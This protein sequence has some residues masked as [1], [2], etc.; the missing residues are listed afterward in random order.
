LDIWKPSQEK[1]PT[2]ELPTVGILGIPNVDYQ[3]RPSLKVPVRNPYFLI[4]LKNAMNK[5]G[6]RL[7]RKGIRPE[8]VDKH[9]FGMR[10]IHYPSN[11][12]PAVSGF[13]F[14]T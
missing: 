11:E 4:G 12:K 13:R 1:N 10:L 2:L 5:P 6:A 9:L 3:A 8:P 14:R 7:F